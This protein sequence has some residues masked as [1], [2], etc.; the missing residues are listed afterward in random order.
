MVAAHSREG[1]AQMARQRSARRSGNVLARKAI[2]KTRK[3]D[4]RRYAPRQS[5]ARTNGQANKKI[6]SVREILA[7]LQPNTANFAP[8]TPVS[9]V[10]RAA[11][12]HPDRTAVI[13]GERRYSYRQFYDRAKRLASALNQAGVKPGV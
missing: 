4:I 1:G 11:E 9:F 12:I 3:V 5:A 6:A 2:G 8:L 7:S 13:H 10:T